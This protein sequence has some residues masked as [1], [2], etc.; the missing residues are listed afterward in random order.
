[1]LSQESS[2]EI[3]FEGLLEEVR[4][5]WGTDFTEELDPT[6]YPEWVRIYFAPPVGCSPDLSR[7]EADKLLSQ[8][9]SGRYPLANLRNGLGCFIQELVPLQEEHPNCQIFKDMHKKVLDCA[10]SLPSEK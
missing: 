8:R 2:R 4:D 7:E 1:M 10:I 3:R 6:R 5:A 9:L